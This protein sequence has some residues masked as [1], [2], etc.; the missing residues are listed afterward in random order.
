MPRQLVFSRV[1][2]ELSIAEFDLAGGEDVFL[3]YTW[4]LENGPPIIRDGDGPPLMEVVGGRPKDTT[5]HPFGLRLGTWLLRDEMRSDEIAAA[6]ELSKGRQSNG[7]EMALLE[8]Q[9]RSLD[10]LTNIQAHDLKFKEQFPEHDIIG[11]QG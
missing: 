1:P 7:N 8:I 10:E 2:V 4:E 9:R 5:T 6:K 11:Q 3:S